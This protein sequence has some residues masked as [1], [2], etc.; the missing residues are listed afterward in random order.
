MSSSA[1]PASEMQCGQFKRASSGKRTDF[2]K[3]LHL[4]AGLKQSTAHTPAP[5]ASS[6]KV[7]LETIDV[8]KCDNSERGSYFNQARQ[9]AISQQQTMN[10]ERR[11][12]PADCLTEGFA[13]ASPAGMMV[14]AMQTVTAHATGAKRTVRKAADVPRLVRLL[15]QYPT[16]C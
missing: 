3:M 4:L 12:Y 2:F 15:V 8:R 16:T 10:R 6:S 11:A 13:V 9:S 7:T 1:H 5:I 14:L